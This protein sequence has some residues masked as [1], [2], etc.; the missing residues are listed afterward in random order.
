M[1][2]KIKK[3][4][5]KKVNLILIIFLFSFC[6]NPSYTPKPKGYPRIFFPERTYTEY[7]PK[8]CPFLFDIPVYATVI[9]DSLFFNEPTEN[10]C[11]MNISFNQLGATIYLSYKSL[12]KNNIHELLEDMHRLTFKHSIKA[13]YIED[14]LIK[15]PNNVSGIYYE[16]GGNAAS[17]VQ[18]FLTDS[19]QHYIRGALYFNT[20]PNIDSLQPVIDFVKTD[21]S[22][23]INTLKWK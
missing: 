20:Q 16:V 14:E 19:S 1:D 10:P 6:S 9:K 3:N 21:I 22:H 7:I 2:K 17:P 5:L 4:Y 8:A 13:E 15:T 18:F 12:N 23:L 11:W